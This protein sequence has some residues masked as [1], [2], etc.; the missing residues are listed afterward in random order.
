MVELLDSAVARVPYD[1][2][3]ITTASRNFVRGR[4][5]IRGKAVPF[6]LFVKHVQSWVR[7][8]FFAEVPP[9]LRE[10]AEAGVP[11]RIEPLVYRSDLRDRLPEGLSG[12]VPSASTTSTRS[13]QRSGWR[14]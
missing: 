6:S 1:I 14:T 8:P 3:S 12:R 2:P 13:R 5:R 4:A 10:M 7:S 11:W 9:D